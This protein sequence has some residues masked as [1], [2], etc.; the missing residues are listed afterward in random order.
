LILNNAVDPN[1]AGQPN[2]TTAKMSVDWIR[3][4]TYAG[5]G[6]VNP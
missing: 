6:S 5:Y 3:Y 2:G 1:A 4:S